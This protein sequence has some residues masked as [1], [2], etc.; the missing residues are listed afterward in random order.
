MFESLEVRNGANELVAEF[1][2]LQDA[3]DWWL[4]DGG[5]V[6]DRLGGDRLGGGE[7]MVNV[8]AVVRPDAKYRIDGDG[9]V[10]GLD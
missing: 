10:V 3:V 2:T 7:P 8:A 9:C 5:R 6:S 1:P 4:Y